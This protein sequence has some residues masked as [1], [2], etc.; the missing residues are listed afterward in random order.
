MLEGG[1]A[2][3]LAVR[4]VGGRLKNILSVGGGERGGQTWKHN[5][6]EQQNAR[7]RTG[8]NKKSLEKTKEILVMN[9]GA[10]NMYIMHHQ[11]CVL[12]T[13]EYCGMLHFSIDKT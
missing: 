13:V 7:K 3:N 10:I 12:K 9:N 11:V 2:T 4:A 1:G 5:E 8:W 6:L